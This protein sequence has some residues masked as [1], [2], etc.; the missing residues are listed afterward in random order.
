MRIFTAQPCWVYNRWY[1]LWC[2]ACK[3]LELCWFRE[4]IFNPNEEFT[5]EEENTKLINSLKDYA[6]IKRR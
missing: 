3:Q 6:K 2:P 1:T 4:I 5:M